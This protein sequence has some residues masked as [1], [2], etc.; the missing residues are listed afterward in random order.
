MLIVDEDVAAKV[1]TLDR[2]I[3]MMEQV[4]AE[5]YCGEA[6][7]YP[8]VAGRGPDGISRFGVK[9]GLVRKR[10][11]VGLKVGSYWPDNRARGIPAHASTTFLLDP[12]TGFPKALVAAS[13][14]TCIRTAA[15]DGVGIKHLSRPE[16]STVAIVGAGHQA[17]FELLAACEVRPVKRALIW[18][19]S[20]QHAEEMAAR[21]SGELGLEAQA[22]SLEDAVRAADIVITITSASEALVK[23]EWVSPG[24]HISAM[25]SDAIG[26]FELD[27]ALVAAGRLFADVVAQSITLGDFEGAFS[28]G[29]ITVDSITPIGAVIEGAPG[30]TSAEEI[31]IYDSSGMALQDLAVA[32]L[33]LANAIERGLAEDRAFSAHETPAH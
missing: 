26:K 5:H 4:F 7:V 22:C 12:K 14:L 17:W 23:R 28:A 19:R 25:G 3:E 16:S 29:T 30:R 13:H 9:S 27:P 11:I 18:N 33:A 15:S 20:S 6:E 32:E 2:A 1:I 31:T 8:V 21:V 24:T 10:D